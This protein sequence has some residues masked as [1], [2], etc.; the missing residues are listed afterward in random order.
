MSYKFIYDLTAN[1][2]IEGDIADLR[3]SKIL[4]ARYVMYVHNDRFDH[5]LIGQEIGSNQ[6]I[7]PE[8]WDTIVE[9]ISTGE[10]DKQTID[11]VLALT[12][13]TLPDPARENLVA[14][15]KSGHI[16]P[17]SPYF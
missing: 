9:K 10:F 15:I 6:I 11:A 16:G 7:A 5:V 4:N 8:H 17:A 1:R 2:P 13:H 14:A 12:T 3:A